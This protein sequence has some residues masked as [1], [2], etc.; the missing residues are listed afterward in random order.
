MIQIIITTNW[1]GA[2]YLPYTEYVNY[3]DDSLAIK[4][5]DK[6]GE[7]IDYVYDYDRLFTCITF[8]CDNDKELEL[9]LP[10]SYYKGYSAY[11][12]I[13][14]KEIK[15]DLTYS[16][17][18]KELVIISSSGKHTYKVLYEGTFVQKVSLIVSCLT[19]V[20][21]IKRKWVDVI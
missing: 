5:I 12:I 6:S 1:G 19:L 8:S 10:L 11:E 2:E 18:Y 4:Y 21:V 7:V 14:E 17:L 3:N 15:I 13:D 16:P 9:M 20:G